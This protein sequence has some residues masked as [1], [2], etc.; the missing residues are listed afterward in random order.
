MRYLFL[1]TCLVTTLSQAAIYRSVG[2]DGQI[3]YSD[4]PPASAKSSSIIKGD[5][6][7][8]KTPTAPPNA[9]TTTSPTG[10]KAYQ[11][12][13]MEF[14][15][16]QIE[17]DERQR[18]AD[19]ESKDDVARNQDCEQA[20]N[21]LTN[22]QN[23]GRIAK[24]NAKGERDFID[25]N[26]RAAETAKT[27]KMIHD[28]CGPKPAPKVTPKPLAPAGNNVVKPQPSGTSAQGISSQLLLKNYLYIPSPG[29]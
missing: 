23:G 2:A 12:R 6:T 21:Q 22:L 15:K 29:L 8:A 4:Q 18:K 3:I 1:I 26:E 25:D 11:E 7:P 24:Y 13:E 19:Q 14:R 20:K 9:E 16:R 28:S 27:Q 10:A 17:A 5:P